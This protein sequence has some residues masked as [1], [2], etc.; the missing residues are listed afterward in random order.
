MLATQEM[1]FL[2]FETLESEFDF[3][4]W[5]RGFFSNLYN[6][7]TTEGAVPLF[8]SFAINQGHF[9]RVEPENSVPL[10][11]VGDI[12]P[13]NRYSAVEHDVLTEVCSH[14]ADIIIGLSFMTF[15]E[16]RKA[17]E[18]A[19]IRNGFS[20]S[21]DSTGRKI[22]AGTFYKFRCFF[23]RKPKPQK[24]GP[25]IRNRGSSKTDCKWNVIFR[26][27]KCD[28]SSNT[29]WRITSLNSQ[30]NHPPIPQ[31]AMSRHTACRTVPT[32]VK[33][34]I[35][36]MKESGIGVPQIDVYLKNKHP[37][38][39][40]WTQR[41]IANVASST[42]LLSSL[43]AQEFVSLMQEE[44]ANDADAFLRIDRDDE[45]R[46]I[47]ACWSFGSMKRKYMCFHDAIGYFS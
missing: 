16:A 30:H 36:L 42:K 40:T 20:C 12:M 31:K 27:E 15:V 26:L 33:D 34:D 10:N 24:L 5:N 35:R 17:L 28:T 2:D 44:M 19:C 13:I 25:I 41:D 3:G 45:L 22:F 7:D 11:E 6:A 43:D 21:I 32:N 47:R 4:D 39:I 9:P 1:D 37:E 46:L 38:G 18:A 29:I 14:P 23:G 8:D